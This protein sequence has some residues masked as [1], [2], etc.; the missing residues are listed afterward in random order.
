MKNTNIQIELGH[1]YNEWLEL[2]KDEEG[3]WDILLEE[4]VNGAI[5]PR[6][7]VVYWLVYDSNNEL[8][9]CEAY[10]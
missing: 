1:T 2:T 4:L 5:E 6:T 3:L 9:L 8:R 7:D 10:N